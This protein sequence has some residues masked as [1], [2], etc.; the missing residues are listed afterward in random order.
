MHS[1][2]TTGFELQLPWPEAET[3]AR[4]SPFWARKVAAGGK[5]WAVLGVFGQLQRVFG[6]LQGVF[7]RRGRFFW[8]L[9]NYRG[10]FGEE[11]AIFLGF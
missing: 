8:L 11:E 1:A 4:Y 2:S 3:T 7:V 5:F 9:A 6:Q 10:L